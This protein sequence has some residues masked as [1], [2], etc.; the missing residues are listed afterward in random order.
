MAGDADYDA[1]IGS[2]LA[3][4]LYGVDINEQNLEGH[5]QNFT[6]FLTIARDPIDLPEEGVKT[7]IAFTIQHRPGALHE[8][9]LAI[10]G[11]N[12]DLTRIES[13]PIAGQPWEYRLYADLRAHS[14]INQSPLQVDALEAVTTEVRVLGQYLE[15]PEGT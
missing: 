3:A 12:V 5:E 2:E 6:R 14:I 7:S 15:E 4:S 13:S 1:A 11:H 9:L 10:A 8:A